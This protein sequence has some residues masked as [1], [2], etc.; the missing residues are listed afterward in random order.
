[1]IESLE[2]AVL[3][4]ADKKGI[5]AKGTP[6]GQWEKTREEVYELLEGI[7]ENDVEAI[8]DAIGD[9]A[10]TIIIQAHMHGLCLGQCLAAAYREIAG[11]TGRMENGVFVKDE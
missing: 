5:L 10:V 11:R 4:W 3:Q 9:V 2:V 6:H 7:E 8:K 1:M